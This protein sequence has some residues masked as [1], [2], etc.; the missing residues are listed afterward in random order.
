MYQCRSR[1]CRRS[2]RVQDLVARFRRRIEA[3]DAET[4]P[5]DAYALA[6]V[7]LDDSSDIVA[8]RC[9]VGVLAEA[10]RSPTLFARVRRLVDTEIDRIRQRSG[11]AFSAK[12]AGAVLALVMGSLILG[13][14]RPEPP[15][16]SRHQ[17]CFS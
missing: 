9:W 7:K 4:A 17:R 8:A 11:D 6:A 2:A 5:L 16:A 12:E 14:S 10:V 13:A 3:L 15:A 1:R